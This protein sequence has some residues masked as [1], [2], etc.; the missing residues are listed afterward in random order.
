M[1][2]TQDRAVLNVAILEM[3]SNYINGNMSDFR[4]ALQSL[5]PS[6]IPYAVARLLGDLP[7]HS[8]GL[9]KQFLVMTNL[10]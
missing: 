8:E 9:I 3:E 1:S 6:V 10:F 2:L 5:D 4:T 7:E